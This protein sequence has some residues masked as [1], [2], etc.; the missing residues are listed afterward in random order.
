MTLAAPLLLALAAM[1]APAAPPHLV[2]S[3]TQR[4][5]AASGLDAAIRPLMSKGPAWIGYAVPAAGDHQ[6]CCFRTTHEIGKAHPGCRLEGEG[7][8]T[9]NSSGRTRLEGAS[10]FLVLLRVDG[11]RVERLRALS[12]DCGIDAGGLPFHW[13]TDVRPAESL[14]LLRGLVGTGVEGA[15]G[16][17]GK[18]GKH[19]MSE[20]ALAAIAMHADP[21]AD[22]MLIE[23]LA[24][25]QPLELRKHA[26]F[27]LGSARGR[28]GYEVLRDLVRRDPSREL[29]EHAVFALSQTGVEEAVDVVI[30]VARE[31]RDAH[32]RGQALFW[33]SQMA[34]E[35]A[36]GAITRAMAEDPETEV[37]KK[38]V[39]ALSQLPRDE[40][41][42]LLIQTARTNRNPEVRKQAM[43]WLGQTKDPRAVAFF[44]EILGR[45]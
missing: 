19:G 5:S 35:K 1:Q 23:L 14:K 11:G 27:W 22:A 44:A 38:A 12:Y 9:V 41:V 37:K 29:R 33:L 32:V 8:F 13:V 17:R 18:S 28:R 4:H 34:G 21:A 39:F 15:L 10:E 25:D 43:F 42:P 6:M 7:A 24:A 26:A 30:A 20:P 3:V 31:D 40:A 2:G 16:K 45:N 36:M